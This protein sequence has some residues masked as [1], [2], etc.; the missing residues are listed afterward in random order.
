MRST[1][2]CGLS[3]H[4]LLAAY[5]KRE[6]T[7]LEV[8][9]AYLTRIG[10]LDPMLHA[11]ITVAADVALRHADLATQRLIKGDP[12]RV[13]EGIPLGL[14]DVF[15][16]AA[17]PTTGASRLYMDRVP[18]DDCLAVGR[19]R[20]SGAVIL[21]KH[22]LHELAAGG[23]SDGRYFPAARNPWDLSRL[24]GGS[25][26]GSACAVAAGLCAGAFGTDTGGSVRW[27]A[28]YC[29]VV[30]FKPTYDVIPRSGVIPLSW[31]LDHCG[32]LARTTND[33]RLLFL[34][35]AGRDASVR[36]PRDA[37]PASLR[38]G[39]P[40]RWIETTPGIDVDVLSAYKDALDIYRGLGATVTLIEVPELD[41]IPT[42]RHVIV[43]A[44]A[45]ACHSRAVTSHRDRVGPRVLNL[46]LQGA[47]ISAAD[48]IDALR[49]RKRARHAM[50][51]A[52]TGIDVLVTPTMPFPAWTFAEELKDLKVRPYPE[53]A[54]FVEPFN[55]TGQPAISVPWGRSRLGLP[56]GVQFVA[57]RGADGFLLSVAAAFEQARGELPGPPAL[58]LS[59]P[60]D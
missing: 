27:P 5:S 60:S 53:R 43:A 47:Q 55:L 42:L 28:S 41:S 57:A 16:V 38:I 51:K 11:Y 15:D 48:Y 33:A 3:I 59:D 39:V 31:T 58:T 45:Y 20:S 24:P 35:A 8:T 37:Q 17:V 56:I 4:E 52:M 13:L 19:L 32:A 1:E 23:P 14:K 36:P 46:L 7:P 50:D 49:L 22:T 21:G 6:L 40:A 26:S 29:G 18:R 10:Q 12:L 25:S 2:I 34:V 54:R 30:G 9:Q 44:E